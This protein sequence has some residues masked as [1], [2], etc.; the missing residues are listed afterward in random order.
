[1]A[2]D[3]LNKGGTYSHTFTTPGTYDYY[4]TIH[5]YMKASVEVGGQGQSQTQNQPQ[6]NQGQNQG[7]NQVEVRIRASTRANNRDSW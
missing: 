7:Q 6:Q 5:P 3:T 4:C 2:S 1:M